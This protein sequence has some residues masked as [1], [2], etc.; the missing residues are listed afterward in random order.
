MPTHVGA[1]NNIKAHYDHT[2]VDGLCDTYDRVGG[3]KVR[4][5][6]GQWMELFRYTTPFGVECEDNLDVTD[7][8][9]VLQGLVELELYFESWNGNGY[10]PTLTFEM[11]KGAPE[12][13]YYNVDEIWFDIFSFGDYANQQPIPDV[14]YT[15]PEYTEA[16]RLKIISSGHNWSSGANGTYNTGN[17]AEF[18]EATHGIKINDVKVYD[19]HLWRT[20][21][22]N[23]AGC[24][25]QAGTWTYQRSGWCPGSIA[26]VWDFDLTD[27]VSNG[28]ANIFYELDPTYIDECHPNYP[29][30]VNGQNSCPKCDAPDNPVLRVSGKVVTYSNNINV[31]D[32]SDVD[33]NENL[34]DFNVNIFP[35]PASSNL[36]FSSDYQNGKLSVLILNAQGQEVKKF[37]FSGSRTIDVSDLSSGVYFVKVLGNTMKTEKI[38][39]K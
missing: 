15:F 16:A 17:A 3:V 13:D 39:I 14:D 36:N 18:Y 28:C 33:V 1:F 4:N 7:F 9:S 24:Q 21:N 5:Y 8:S 2:C 35:N 27:Y 29:D 22:P 6:R 10:N 34:V 20:C 38:I 31:L 12:F 32:G 30:C 26:M 25:P 11:T 23:P 37:A 19:Q